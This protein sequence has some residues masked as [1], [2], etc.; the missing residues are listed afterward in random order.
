MQTKEVRA[1]KNLLR[2]Y[3]FY[4]ERINK[5]EED[6][7][8]CY[9]K[10]GGVRAVDPSREPIHSPMDKDIEYKIRDDIEKYEALMKH[11]K[12]NIDYVDSVL[13][14]IEEETREAIKKVY[15]ESKTLESVSRKIYISASTLRDRIDVRLKLAIRKKEG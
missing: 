12:S 15:V 5:L 7:D 13:E 8:L 3:K 4:Q 2:N 10:L 11:Y 14:L 9:H 1:F 6:I